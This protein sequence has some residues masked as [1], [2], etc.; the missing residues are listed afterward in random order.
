LLLALVGGA[1]GVELGGG[2]GEFHPSGG[3]LLGGLAQLLGLAVML[4][5]VPLLSGLQS[6]PRLGQLPLQPGDLLDLA[7]A[8]GAP[9]RARGMPAVL[10]AGVQRNQ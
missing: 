9:T 8:V 6:L 2:R 3:C 1:F 10:A 4:G 7:V 5:A